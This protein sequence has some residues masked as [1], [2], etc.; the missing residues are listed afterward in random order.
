MAMLSATAFPFLFA[1]RIGAS[2]VER[3][4]GFVDR[5]ERPATCP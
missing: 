2:R 3:V 5:R 4:M 1:P